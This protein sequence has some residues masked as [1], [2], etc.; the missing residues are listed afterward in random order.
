M[1]GSENSIVA[2]RSGVMVTAEMTA[3][4][5]AVLQRREDAVEAGVD[6]LRLDAQLPRDR[7][8]DIDVEAAELAAFGDAERR[9][10]GI[11][12]DA[13]P[14]AGAHALERR[15]RRCASSGSANTSSVNAPATTR[16]SISECP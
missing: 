7:P 15:R 16:R 10:G 5:R 2:L 13:Q 3:S 14:A 1:Y 9:I 8:R 6:E 11:D 12:P 4:K